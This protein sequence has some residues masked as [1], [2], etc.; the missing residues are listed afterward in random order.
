MFESAE[1]GHKVD[2]EKFDKEQKKLRAE[3]LAMQGELLEAKKFPVVVLVNGVDGAG[4]GDTINKFN[5]WLDPRHVRTRA[6]GNPT[7]DERMRPPMWR[8]WQALP[9][10]GKI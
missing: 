7:E 10:K 4:K 9:A 1:L 5:E 6:F 8:F 2:D 3:L